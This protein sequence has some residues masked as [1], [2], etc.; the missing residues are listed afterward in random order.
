MQGGLPEQSELFLPSGILQTNRSPG[1]RAVPVLVEAD[2]VRRA[3]ARR[4]EV[5]LRIT[6]RNREVQSYVLRNV[7]DPPEL[8]VAVIMQ[9]GRH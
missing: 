9:T 2:R 5:A 8:I 7:E 3:A 4:T 1:N 6:E